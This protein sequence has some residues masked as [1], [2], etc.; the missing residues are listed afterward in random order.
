MEKKNKKEGM[1]EYV[2]EDPTIDTSLVMDTFRAEHCEKGVLK[3]K[4]MRVKPDM[5]PHIFPELKFGENGTCDPCAKSCVFSVI[6]S[7]LKTE[8]A[9]V[10]GHGP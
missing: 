5:S 7:K 1:V 9:V 2:A 10:R 4:G 3:H 8:E 6:E